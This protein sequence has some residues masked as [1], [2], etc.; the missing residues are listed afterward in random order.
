VP[1]QNFPKALPD[2]LLGSL[3]ARGARQLGIKDDKVAL[4]LFFGSRNV[5]PSGLMQG[6]IDKLLQHIGHI[7]PISP[8]ELLQQHTLLPLFRPFSTNEKH[9]KLVSDLRSSPKNFSMLRSGINATSLNWPDTFKVC[10]QCWQV[11][12]NAYGFAI[13]Q[14]LFQCP[15]VECCP[16]HK[17]LLLNTRVPVAS[18]RRHQLVGTHEYQLESAFNVV[19]DAKLRQLSTCIEQLLALNHTFITPHQWTAFYQTL[20]R[21]KGMLC[22]RRI[23]HRAIRNRVLGYWGSDQLQ[24]WGVMPSG[25]CDWLLSMFRTHRRPFNYLQ[26]LVVLLALKS[27][28]NMTEVVTRAASCPDVAKSKKIYQNDRA[29]ERRGEYRKEWRQLLADGRSL[30]ELRSTGEGARIYSWLY[31]YDRD[32]LIQNKPEAIHREV[33]NRIDWAA[34][35]RA[36]ARR[37]F[38][39]ERSLRDELAGPRRSISWFLR[40]TA[41][42]GQFDK[43]PHLFPLCGLLLDRYS[44]NVDEYQARRLASSVLWFISEKKEFLPYE[45]ERRAGLS[46][47]RSRSAARIILRSHVSCWSGVTEVSS[48]HSA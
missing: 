5:V 26:H 12:Q 17:C 33:Q 41:L 1:L 2:E 18:E 20:A 28:L 47:K 36:F 11:Q 37:I 23:D 35:D 48:Q 32:W 42:K 40:R 46:E 8:E 30:K 3:L 13:W 14:R 16:R 9:S 38:R 39:L 4:E 7:W 6:H 24:A 22:G 27:Q 45:I 43:K 21:T 15:G 29:D 44:E 25:E 34:R 31:R 19:A 10:P